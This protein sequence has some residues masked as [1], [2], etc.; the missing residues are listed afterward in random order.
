MNRKNQ[1][2]TYNTLNGVFQAFMF[3]FDEGILSDDHVLASAVWR[4]LFEM[5]EIEDFSSVATMCD[6]IRKNVAHMDKISELDLLRNGVVT[7]VDR[8]VKE[9]DHLKARTKILDEIRRKEN[10]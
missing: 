6:Y 9:L 10:E 3:G 2:K 5:K 4:H 1:L 8:D 7:F